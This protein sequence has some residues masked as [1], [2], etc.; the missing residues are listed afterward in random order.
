MFDPL[1]FFKLPPNL[2][3]SEREKT[4]K[5]AVNPSFVGSPGAFITNQ[6]VAL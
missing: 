3:R 2:L 6:A 1:Q 5:L 4:L